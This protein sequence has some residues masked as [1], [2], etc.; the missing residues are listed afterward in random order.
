MGDSVAQAL[1]PWEKAC[2]F[3]IPIFK[4]SEMAGEKVFLFLDSCCFK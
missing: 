1:E 2:D 4:I 3:S